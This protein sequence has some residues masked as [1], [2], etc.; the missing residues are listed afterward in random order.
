VD[1]IK[2]F[3][4]RIGAGRFVALGGTI[5]AVGIFLI[6]IAIRAA[7]P[8]M[9]L[10]FAQIDAADGGRVMD[11]LKALSMPFEIRGDGTQIYVPD[12]DVARLRM[13]LAQEGLPAGGSVGYELFDKS[14]VFSTTSALLDLNYIRALEGE[15]S[16]S[17]RTIQGV[18]GCRV[19]LVIPKRELFSQTRQDPSASVVL[20]MQGGARLSTSQAQS[21]QH[22]ISSAVSGLSLDKI[23]IIDDKGTLLAKGRESGTA[24]EGINAQDGLKRNTEDRLAR[25]IEGLL[26]KTLGPG[27]T[28]AEVSADIDFDKVTTTSVEFD[29]DGQVARSINSTQE[30]NDSDENNN[31]TVSVQNALPEQNSA[32]GASKSQS[33][34][35]EEST[36]FEI[37]NATKTHIKEAGSVKRLSVAV[38]VDGHYTHDPDGKEVYTPRSEQDLEQ[39]TTLVKT[40]VG[41]KEERGDVVKV[42]NMRFS[43]AE[44][45]MDVTET[46]WYA[47]LNIAKVIELSLLGLFGLLI[48]L[49]VLRPILTMLLRN[50]HSGRG[51]LLD[52]STGHIGLSN[53]AT[54]DTGNF[55]YDS[56]DAPRTPYTDHAGTNTSSHLKSDL[57]S[58]INMEK[59]EGRVQVSSIKKMGELVEKHPEETLHI[60]RSWI[61][62][63]K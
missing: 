38:L 12:T 37:S 28:R 40:A 11:K 19:H 47:K 18:A 31:D 13:E 27:K 15:L 6:Y 4:Q 16:K 56:D 22:L 42:I 58:L 23:S 53:Y 41:F 50:S 48:G 52:A 59:I 62:A 8:D 61:Y 55:I 46:A 51:N 32:L 24:N 34:R 35:L 2:D 33:S 63:D 5:L 49:F 44:R 29:P 39:L 7:K 9:A 20:K 17:I 45:S 60:L 26:E 36:N 14:D 54:D 1:A 21:I 3:I 10:L 57:I 43:E 25:T 30:G